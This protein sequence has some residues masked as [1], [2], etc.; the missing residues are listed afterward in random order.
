MIP[1]VS[2]NVRGVPVRALSFDVSFGVNQIPIAYVSIDPTFEGG[3]ILK[4]TDVYRNPRAECVIT[5]TSIIG[6]VTDVLTFPCLFDGVSYNMTST[7]YAYTAIFKSRWQ[8][9]LETIPFMPGISPLGINPYKRDSILSVT[10]DGSKGIFSDNTISAVS[11]DSFNLAQAFVNSLVV[12][13]QQQLKVTPVDVYSTEGGANVFS[14][15][16]PKMLNGP[17]YVKAL[18]ELNILMNNIDYSAVR[19]FVIPSTSISSYKVLLDLFTRQSDDN[20]WSFFLSG[21]DYM[22]MAVIVG[23]TKLFVIPKA[24]FIKSGS[25]DTPSVKGNATVPN[26]APPAYYDSIN[27]NDG[28]YVD[29]GSVMIV[30]FP[31]NAADSSPESSP[32]MIMPE[33]SSVVGVIGSYPSVDGNSDPTQYGGLVTIE[34]SS[35]LNV[36]IQLSI[37]ASPSMQPMATDTDKESRSSMNSSAITPAEQNKLSEEIVRKQRELLDN[38][39]QSYYLGIK[40]GDRTGSVSLLYHNNWVPGTTGTAYARNPGLFIDFYATQ[41]SHSFSINGTAKTNVSFVSGRMG[42]NPVGLDEDKLYL[43]NTSKMQAVQK[44]FLKDTHG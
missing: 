31:F 10:P 19:D 39:A 1:T 43:Y 5:V 7:G 44:A 2:I 26:F 36:I 35:F 12:M 27:F 32:G 25:R 42:N 4:N 17:S 13:V 34:A 28:G 38:I 24:Q 3:L 18:A 8:Y 16:L 41:V 14:Q 29:V 11:G 6:G 22:G 20:L 30:T 23:P 9:F 33:Q 40:Y 15:I 21:L 37:P